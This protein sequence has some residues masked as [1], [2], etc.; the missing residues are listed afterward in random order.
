MVLSLKCFCLSGA[1]AGLRAPQG[2]IEIRGSSFLFNSLASTF[3]V[4]WLL[5]EAQSGIA[6]VLQ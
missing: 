4:L 5:L 1:L 2:E 3:I 6:E